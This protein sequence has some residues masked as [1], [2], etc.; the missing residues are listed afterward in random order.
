MPYVQLGEK[1]GLNVKR[2]VFESTS[3]W[4]TAQSEAAYVYQSHSIQRLY[5]QVP[6]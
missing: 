3:S 1:W 6:P 5:W 4:H 2:F